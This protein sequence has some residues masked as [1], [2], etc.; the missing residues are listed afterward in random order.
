[1]NASHSPN[2]PRSSARASSTAGHRF[3][4]WAAAYVFF[5][6]LAFS[7]APSPLYVLYA[8]RDHF[9]SFMVT[10][11]YAAYAVG[12]L[13]SLFLVSHRSDVHGRRV[14]LMAAVAIAIISTLVFIVW[15]SLPG[16]FLAR[17]LC[18]V[19]VGLTASTATA[20]LTELHRARHAEAKPGRPQLV[21]TS[22]NLFG[23]SVGALLAGLLAQYVGDP[24]VLP[25]LV[26]LAAL[27]VGAIALAISPETRDR[28]QSM[29][30]YHPQRV[31]IPDE[32]RPAFFAAASGVFMAY[33]G[34]G[35]LT[36]LAGTFLVTLVHDTSL[37][38]AGL[39]IFIIFTVGVVFII[40]TGAWPARRQIIVGF[41]T[42]RDA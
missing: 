35:I 41:R 34:L 27:V 3:G 25:Y 22:A 33:G 15:P 21:A 14:H 1:M 36:G 13:G 29:P 39:T 12:I 11:I 20:Y 8:Q 40:A 5:V 10:L 23:L 9:S 30:P 4:F 31:S 16:L 17:I 32:A 7:A 38:M 18:G 42:A 6:V 37:A 2:A 26:I 28:P 19:A 24:L